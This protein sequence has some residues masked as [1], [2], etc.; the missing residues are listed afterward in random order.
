MDVNSLMVVT[1]GIAFYF[2]PLV[3]LFAT[4]VFVMRWRSRPAAETAPIPRE[5]IKDPLIV[6]GV[7]VCSGIAM[8]AFLTGQFRFGDYLSVPADS[9]GV[10]GDALTDWDDPLAAES[11][12]LKGG[13]LIAVACSVVVI[14][15]VLSH[16]RRR[17]RGDGRSTRGRA[18]HESQ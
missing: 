5:A 9:F 18:E 2:I 15:S 6:A 13:V 7:L 12:A 16:F 17:L 4:L 3:L 8:V 1:M 10:L 11:I 14:F